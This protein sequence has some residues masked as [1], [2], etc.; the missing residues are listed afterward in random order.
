MN[1]IYYNSLLKK[2]LIKFLFNFSLLKVINE[3]LPLL[4]KFFLDL[5]LNVFIDNPDVDNQFFFT[6]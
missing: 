3:L 6:L 4:F 5:N 1:N 2:K